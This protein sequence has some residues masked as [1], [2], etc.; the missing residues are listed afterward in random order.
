M[1]VLLDGESIGRIEPWR[2]R[3]WH[4]SLNVPLKGG[5]SDHVLIQGFGFS[6]DE[7]IANAVMFSI[8]DHQ[9]ALEAIV[10][11]QKRRG[12]EANETS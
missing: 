3:E 1:E 12:E 11:F 9:A 8:C 4:A 10:A 2:E 5:R 7:A 6:H